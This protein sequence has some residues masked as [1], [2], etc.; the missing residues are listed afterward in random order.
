M[1]KIEYIGYRTEEGEQIFRASWSFQTYTVQVQ[2]AIKCSQRMVGRALWIIFKPLLYYWKLKICNI[3]NKNNKKAVFLTKPS[4]RA[5]S[6]KHATATPRKDLFLGHP[7]K[8]KKK[9]HA[10]KRTICFQFFFFFPNCLFPFSLFNWTTVSQSLA[11]LSLWA[12]A[13]YIETSKL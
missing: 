7:L 9:T 13:R 6:S 2:N 8:K 1:G 3:S 4:R 5:R 12:F 10:K 11:S